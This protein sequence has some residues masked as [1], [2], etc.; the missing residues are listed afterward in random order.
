MIMLTAV[1]VEAH[2]YSRWHYPWPQAGCRAR[3][4]AVH[5]PAPIPEIEPILIPPGWDEEQERREALEQAARK[6]KLHQEETN[7][8]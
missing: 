8:D 7:G 1:P 5:K 3:A 2:C 4:I 6:L